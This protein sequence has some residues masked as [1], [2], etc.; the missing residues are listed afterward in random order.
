MLPSLFNGAVTR[1]RSVKTGLAKALTIRINE[2]ASA[3]IQAD[4][5]PI[6]S[7][8]FEVTILARALRFCV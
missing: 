3:T 7:G 4:G 6:G 2:T 5:E 1:K 8:N